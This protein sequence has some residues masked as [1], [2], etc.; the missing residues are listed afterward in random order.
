MKGRP[1]LSRPTGAACNRC[2]GR[3]GMDIILH[4][5]VHRT[6]TTSFQHYMRDSADTLAQGAIG[7]WGPM[8]TRKS[9]FPGLFPGPK[10][11]RGRS[12]SRRAEGRVR[13]LLELAKAG[14]TR[15]LVISDE[16][17]IGTPQQCMRQGALYPAIGDRMARLDAAFGGKVTRIVLSLRAQDLFWASLAA[18]TVGRGHGLPDATRL[19]RI[20]HSPRTWRDVITDLA[21]AMPEAEIVVLPFE[22]VA[23]QPNALLTAGTGAAAP[24][25]EKLHWLNKSPDLRT[26]RRLVAER[27]IDP[28]PVMPEGEG[29]W[30]PFSRAQCAQLAESYAD[31][32]HWLI[33]G[34]DGLAHLTEDTSRN[35]KGSSLPA[36]DMTK[37]HG[38]DIRHPPEH[39][40][41]SG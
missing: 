2:R 16:N 1:R 37:G 31:D 39:L 22:R 32:M 18:Y 5:G 21:C 8:R 27:G 15:Q 24:R 26:L 13:I 38:H 33:A 25:P 11:A 29:R 23:G 17:M 30:Q 10:T 4:L 35:R 9:V 3:F 28:D 34:A 40:A 20:A 7:F 19:D 6:G 14:G 36:G 41:Q 12:L